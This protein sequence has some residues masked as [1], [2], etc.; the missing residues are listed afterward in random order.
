M[1]Q[2]LAA[3]GAAAAT[4]A[5]LLLGS[6]AA[7]A[8]PPGEVTGVTFGPG[9][10]ITWT[11]VAGS[12]D[13]NIYRG[14]VSWLFAGDGAECHGDEIAGTSFTSLPEPPVGEAF[15]YWVTAESDVDGEGTAG[16][17]TG[18]SGRPLRGS[19][20]RIARHHLLD[21]AGFGGD[22]WTRARLD[23]LGRQAYLDKRKEAITQRAAMTKLF[24]TEMLGR[25]ADAAVQV[26]G[27]MGYM[28]EL[29]IERAYRDARIYRIY[30]GTSEI[31]RLV[32]AGGL[33]DDR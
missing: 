14:V 23:L 1:H 4:G 5:A 25:V 3:A 6:G 21:R 30:E 28:K 7:V 2:R 13:Y 33:L 26:H 10:Q 15:F 27:G 31:Q 29:W 32:I 17:G 16:A 8:A 20:D 12:N 24:A 22:E 18:G 19:C 11:S 9:S